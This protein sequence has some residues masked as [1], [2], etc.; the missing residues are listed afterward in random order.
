MAKYRVLEE[1]DA[2]GAP[3]PP[4]TRPSDYPHPGNAGQVYAPSR[5]E[6]A[7][8]AYFYWESRGHNGG[9]PEADWFRAEK[10][11]KGRR[12]RA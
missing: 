9:S 8:L 1:E 5:E 12:N 3:T 2:I 10:E 6:I 11:L 4:T 7:R